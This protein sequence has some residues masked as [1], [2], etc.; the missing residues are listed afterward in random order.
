[1]KNT[2]VILFVISLLVLPL[3]IYNLFHYFS[4]NKEE[5]VIE[6][7]KGEVVNKLSTDVLNNV[8]Y[9]NYIEYED[10]IYIYYSKVIK[11]KSVEGDLIRLDKKSLLNLIQSDETNEYNDL[12][13]K[14]NLYLLYNDFSNILS[15]DFVTVKE[16]IVFESDN[17][18]TD[19][20]DFIIDSSFVLKNIISELSNTELNKVI[21]KDLVNVSNSSA[22]TSPL[23]EVTADTEIYKFDNFK[24]VLIKN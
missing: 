19:Y 4:V 13:S 3:F 20:K 12:K 2:K 10:N 23:V 14:L 18:N 8:I 6:K 22:S 7:N 15:L 11:D 17:L 9:S 24:N 5:S 21:L 1:M 16:N